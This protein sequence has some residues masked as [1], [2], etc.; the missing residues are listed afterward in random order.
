MKAIVLLL[1]LDVPTSA[2]DDS[3][4]TGRL[5][6]DSGPEDLQVSATATRT[7]LLHVANASRLQTADCC[8]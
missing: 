5:S 3:N 8:R 4:S 2:A 7:A 1:F 6:A